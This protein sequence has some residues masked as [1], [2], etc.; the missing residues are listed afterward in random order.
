MNTIHKILIANRGEIA[1]RIIR[2]IKEMGKKSVAVY[3]IADRYAPFV[4]AADEAVCIGNAPSSE[5]YLVID[6]I[7]D[8]AK[9]TNC[10]AIHPGYGFLSENSNFAKRLKEEGLI[11]IGPDI[12]AIEMMGNKLTAKQAAKKHGVPLL[13]GTEHPIEDYNEAL[14]IAEQ[15]GFPILIKAA[16]GGGGKGMRVVNKIDELQE[17][18]DRAR[19]EAISSFGDGSVFIEKFVVTP[20]HIEIQVFADK[21]NNYVYLFE[22]DCS[23][24]RRHQKVIE[25]APS[26]IL[27]EDKRRAMGESA[28]KIAKACNYVGAGT[29]EF[30]YDTD[31]SF[32]FLEMN[33]RLQVEHPVTEMITGKDLVKEQIRVAEGYPL[34]FTQEDLKINGH[35]VEVRVYAE[36]PMN[37]FLPD[38]GTLSVCRFPEG[39]GVRID[40]GFREDMEVSVYYDPMIAKLIVHADTRE[41]AIEKL[42]RAIKETQIVGI[43][44]TLDF[45]MFC[46]NHSEFISGTMDTNF[47]I[48]YFKP[49]LLVNSSKDEE[50]IAVLEAIHLIDNHNNNTNNQQSIDNN[51][52]EESNWYLNRMIKR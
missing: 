37:N 17:A 8:A 30:L 4:L 52:S 34:S 3:S 28:L 27:Q 35:A 41:N 6:K 38:T 2:S 26:A 11:F 7:I 22:R 5:S 15:I 12:E 44:T 29:V 9:A 43:S 19:S 1:L 50:L 21:H 42:K 51:K 20:K 14:K 40:S 32:Y 46:I 47:V 10:D 25:E 49:E 24:Q 16:A 48:K 13:P 23:I 36:D 18:M 31:G 45:A 39:L 33:T